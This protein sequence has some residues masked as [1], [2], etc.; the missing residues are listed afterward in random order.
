M[1]FKNPIRKDNGKQS[2]QSEKPSQEKIKENRET[3]KFSDRNKYK[4][5][6]NFHKY[7]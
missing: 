6:N 1:K 3:T 7:K 5:I 4:N 2:E